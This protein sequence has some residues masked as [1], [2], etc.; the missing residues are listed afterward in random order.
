MSTFSNIQE[1][2]KARGDEWEGAAGV[3]LSN[4]YR[5]NEMAG[6]LGECF[7][8]LLTAIAL[9][10]AV[11]RACNWLKKLDRSALGMVGSTSNQEELGDELADVIITAHNSARQAGIDLNAATIR[12][13]NKTSDKYGFATRMVA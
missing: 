8:R 6:E 9:G 13:F 7:E 3:E 2:A 1:A 11:G 12:K 10:T 5:G 4:S